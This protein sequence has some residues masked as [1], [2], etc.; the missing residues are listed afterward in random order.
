MKNSRN[1]Y[2]VSLSICTF[3]LLYLFVVVPPVPGQDQEQEAPKPGTEAW[4]ISGGERG[5][6]SGSVVDGNR[7]YSASGNQKLFALRTDS[8]EKI[9]TKRLPRRVRSTPLVVKDH[10]YFATYSGTVYRVQKENG[11]ED[12]TTDVSDSTNSPIAYWN[13][14][15]Y[16]NGRSGNV[17]CLNAEN[18]EEVWQK[19]TEDDVESP[20]AVFGG[21]V[22]FGDEDNYVYS[23]NA[24]SGEEIWRIEVDANVEVGPA[25][26][27]GRVITAS[28]GG[29]VYCLDMKSGNKFWTKKTDSSTFRSSPVMAKNRVIIAGRKGTLY[30]F[31]LQKGTKKWTSDLGERVYASPAVIGSRVYVA[32]RRG[33]LKVYSVDSGQ[34]EWTYD[35]GGNLGRIY[36]GPSAADGKLFLGGYKG[37]LHGVHIRNPGSEQVWRRP[38]KNIRN[39]GSITHPPI[40]KSYR[41]RVED[42]WKKMSTASPSTLKKKIDDFPDDVKNHPKVKLL[43]SMVSV[44]EIVRDEEEPLQNILPHTR[45]I[46]RYL[47]YFPPANADERKQN[48]LDVF[49]DSDRLNEWFHG[50]CKKLG[51][52]NY[53]KRKKATD[54]L[55]KA[56][57]LSRPILR[58]YRDADD[59]EVR[60]RVRYLLK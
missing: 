59:P 26:G 22:F 12:W 31:G 19:Q 35:G 7:L 58:E 43:S 50:L 6:Y 10:L 53:Q 23:L 33:K 36:T 40:K 29:N 52:R 41:T 4:S 3:I 54:R 34:L 42:I 20:V 45:E 24:E 9:W 8:G 16:I 14:K 27:K 13:G 21:R 47:L 49:S 1:R 28:Y 18:G 51:N 15:L 60:K 48:V 25:V 30:C 46:S 57:P 17:Y 37:E 32:T 11:E 55:R 2:P 5:F 44:M 39:T 56:L 38:R